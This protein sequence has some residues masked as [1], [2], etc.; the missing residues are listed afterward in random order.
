MGATDDGA[1][2]DYVTFFSSFLFHIS[3]A[4]LGVCM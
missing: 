4:R 3:R 1:F 2:A